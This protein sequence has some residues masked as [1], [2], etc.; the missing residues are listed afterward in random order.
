MQLFPFIDYTD[1]NNVYIRY[2]SVIRRLC[3]H[4]MSGSLTF[5]QFSSRMKKVWP[6]PLLII[7]LII[8]SKS[9]FPFLMTVAGKLETKCSDL[10][11]FSSLRRGMF[12]GRERGRRHLRHPAG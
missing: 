1:F 10:S 2:Q 8:I 4:V 5:K 9:F 11:L 12:S 6:R 7:I 3:V